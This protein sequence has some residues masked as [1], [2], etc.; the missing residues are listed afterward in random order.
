M[1]LSDA[2]LVAVVSGA[3]NAGVVWGVV[4]TQ[5]AWHRRDIDRAQSSAD[6]AHDRIDRLHSRV[7][8]D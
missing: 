5:L 8:A 4:R 6:Q 3:V 2:L 1:N 7:G